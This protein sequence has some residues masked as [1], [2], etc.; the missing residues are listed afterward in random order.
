[1]SFYKEPLKL[2]EGYFMLHVPIFKSGVC[3]KLPIQSVVTGNYSM[4]D[5]LNVEFGIVT[6]LVCI[7]GTYFS[8]DDQQL[9]FFF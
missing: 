2:K 4:V 3:P 5:D 7:K 8:H 9:N 6:L 1:M